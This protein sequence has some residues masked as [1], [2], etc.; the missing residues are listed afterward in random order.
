MAQASSVGTPPAGLLLLKHEERK[1]TFS[2]PR[3]WHRYFSINDS[4]TAAFVVFYSD[5]EGERALD[6]YS[7]RSFHTRSTTFSPLSPAF[8]KLIKISLES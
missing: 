5:A 4:G 1:R 3:A 6:M 8:L 2:S 7:F